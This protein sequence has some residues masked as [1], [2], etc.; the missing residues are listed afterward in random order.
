MITIIYIVKVTTISDNFYILNWIHTSENRIWYG[1]RTAK[2]SVNKRTKR[3]I[4]ATYFLHCA[5]DLYNERKLSG[6]HWTF[7]KPFGFLAVDDLKCMSLYVGAK[8][9]EL[10]GLRLQQFEILKQFLAIFFIFNQL[11]CSELNFCW[12]LF[13]KLNISTF[14]E[15]FTTN[16][17]FHTLIIQSKISLEKC[18]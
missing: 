11:G 13:A 14:T 7:N 15:N 2:I 10:H 16:R 6:F 3:E 1:V 18:F 12:I 5:V 8:I 4:Q 9:W 17:S